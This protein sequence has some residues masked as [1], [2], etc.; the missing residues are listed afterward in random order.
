MIVPAQTYIA[1]ALAV[2]YAGATPVYVD[3]E[4][5]YYGLDPDRLGAAITEKTKA[6]IMVHLYGQVGRWAE[7]AA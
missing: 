1:T 4:P 2:T 5:H 3:I 6:I 7:V